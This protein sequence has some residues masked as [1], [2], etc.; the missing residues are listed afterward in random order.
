MADGEWRMGVTRAARS[1]FLVPPSSL[2]VCIALL[3][4]GTVPAMAQV[5]TDPTR[6]PAELAAEIPA[7]E[8]AASPLHRLQSVII[9][10]KRRAAIIN[11]QVVELGG[12]YGDAI[13]TKVEEDEVV[14]K[15][16][17]SQEVLKLYPSVE[18]V[19]LTPGQA[20][21][22]VKAKARPNTAAQPGSSPSAG[23]GARVR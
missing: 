15:S 14:L 5:L 21:P 8:G 7:V 13:L 19:Q 22:K 12:K 11:G 6:P 3:A 23:G 1:R 4:P 10:P 2:A 17:T 16:D 9:S 18:K 20:R